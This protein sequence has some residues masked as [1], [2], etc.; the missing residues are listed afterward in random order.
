MR[1]CGSQSSATLPIR[2]QVRYLGWAIV[3][4]LFVG[5]T[6]ISRNSPDRFEAIGVIFAA[7]MAARPIVWSLSWRRAEVRSVGS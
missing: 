2:S 6:G 5:F 3:W 7:V 1:G 4:G